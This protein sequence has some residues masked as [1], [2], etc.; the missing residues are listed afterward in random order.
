MALVAW[1]P[2]ALDDV[3]AIAAYIARDSRAYA[4]AV[5]QKII[6]VTRSLQQFPLSGRIVPEL[7]DP[8]MREKFADNYRVI[9]RVEN[10]TVT[11]ATVIHG[12]RQFESDELA[13]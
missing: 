3:D 11:I 1:S 5:V 7:N 10:D 8:A 9:Y 4:A 13:D 12:K 6:G 2:K